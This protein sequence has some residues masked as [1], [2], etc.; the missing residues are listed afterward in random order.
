M[1]ATTQENHSRGK[2][3][4]HGWQE[5]HD[6]PCVAMLVQEPLAYQWETKSANTPARPDDTHSLALLLVEPLGEYRNMHEV[7]EYATNAEQNTLG[8]NDLPCDRAVACS[9]QR[10]GNDA[11]SGQDK[12]QVMLGS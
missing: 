6:R 10:S 11:D 8:K 1:I 5:D 12:G 2:Q 9:N 7:Q 3:C 4:D